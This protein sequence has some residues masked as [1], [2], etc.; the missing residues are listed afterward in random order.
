MNE[1][2]P[3]NWTAMA[4]S[5]LTFI[6][7][8][9]LHSFIRIIVFKRRALFNC[10]FLYYGWIKGW[11]VLGFVIRI[12][13]CML[14]RCFQKPMKYFYIHINMFFHIRQQNSTLIKSTSYYS[15]SVLLK[16]AGT[17]T[18]VFISNVSFHYSKL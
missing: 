10:T 6:I 9:W 15:I 3:L 18:R 14:T 16:L 4:T 8:D 7:T 2:W 12:R 17:Y 5:F 1:K 13:F 11:V